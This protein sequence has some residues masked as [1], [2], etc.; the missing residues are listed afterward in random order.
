[1]GTL[2]ITAA[3]FANLP[4]TAPANWPP[5]IVYPA[6][7][8]PNGS[9]VY[10]WTDAD[11]LRT[12]TW[13]AGTQYQPPAGQTPPYTVTATQLLLAYVQGWINATAQNERQ[14]AT[15]TIVPAPINPT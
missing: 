10:T 9:K 13:V 2:T 14:Y 8:S 11:W 4:A 1:M 7:G 15:Q 5:F 6:G 3:G 12:I